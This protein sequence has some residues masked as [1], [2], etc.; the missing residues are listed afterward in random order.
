LSNVLHGGFAFMGQLRGYGRTALLVCALFVT[1]SCAMAPH[2]HVALEDL[3]LVSRA[4]E[5]QQGAFRV[6]AAVP[7]E[8]E[9][10]RLFG[11]PVYDRGIQPVWLEVTNTGDR[12][13]RLTL[14]S[15]D[16]KYFSPFEVAYI[17]RKRLSKD[18]W[19]DLE[20]WLYE[21]ALPRQVGARETVSGFVFTHLNRGTKAFNVDVF[22]TDGSRNFEQFTFFLPV[23][24]FVPDHAVI[25]FRRM[26]AEDDVSDVDVNGLRALLDRIPC[27]TTDRSGERRDRPLNLFFVAPGTDLLRAL[28]RAGWSETAYERDAAYLASAEYFFERVPDAI[29]RKGRDG[30]TERAELSLW[31]APIR[32]DGV[33]LWVGQ[34]RHAI[35][36]RFALTERV[37]GVT[38][39]PD[40][41]DGRNYV[42]QDLWYAQSLRHWA[43]SD[44]GIEVPVDAPLTDFDGRPWFT[45]DGYRLVLWISGQ[46]VALT[47]AREIV[48]DLVEP[49]GGGQQP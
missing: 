26:Y 31:L 41:S 18:G 6:R 15:I 16:P 23:P 11:I 28:L 7:G 3:D 43:W 19:R 5:Q 4:Q 48:W 12:R 42:L 20:A 2:R 24:G 9:A 34:V 22:Q 37:L 8:D 27:C 38:L 33:P 1:A 30:T 49:S 44:S 36:R 17:H 45:R 14:S 39:D 40:T 21:N 13:A 29:F 32:V 35:G 10:E 47:Q 46:P 25:D